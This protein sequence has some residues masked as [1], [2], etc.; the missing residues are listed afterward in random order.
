[1]TNDKATIAKAV[2]ILEKYQIRTVEWLG[3]ES[4][5]EVDFERSGDG[6]TLRYQGHEISVAT[7]E[8]H[9]SMA[10]GADGSTWDFFIHFDQELVLQA[11]AVRSYDEG[12]SR[13]GVLLTSS[14]IESFKAGKWL[15]MLGPCYE[16]LKGAKEK[17]ERLE[18][19]AEQAE[20]A[21]KI[22]LGNYGD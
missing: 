2:E 18:K 7:G 1:M 8:F 17:K 15:E 10:P 20:Q 6:V 5:D 19:E 21:S 11:P 9:S 4:S 14:T 16:N 22:D 13:I 3:L 12:G